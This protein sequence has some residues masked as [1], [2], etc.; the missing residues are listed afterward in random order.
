MTK[1]NILTVLILA[2]STVLSAALRLNRHG[3]TRYFIYALSF[4]LCASGQN[5]TFTAIDFPGAPSTL[6]WGI[7]N[8]GDIVGSYMLGNISHGFRLSGG[9]FVTI[10]YPGAIHTSAANVS[11]Q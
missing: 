11:F 4:A 7:N 6:A 9:Q 5:G 2:V 8:S 3:Q 1:G 10:D